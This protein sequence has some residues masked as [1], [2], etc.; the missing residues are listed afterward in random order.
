MKK[1]FF[2]FVGLIIL[3]GAGCNKQDYQIPQTISSTST[4][5]YSD[6]YN[7]L[8]VDVNGDGK[9][10]LITLTVKRFEGYVTTTLYVNDLSVIVPGYDPAGYFGMVDIDS[11]DNIR[12][13]AV[14]DVGPSD[15]YTTNFYYF[16]G[17]NLLFMGTIPWVYK[18]MTFDGFGKIITK[19]RGKIL[20]TWFYDDDFVIS[21]NHELVHVPKNL[22]VRDTTVTLLT[23][24]PLQ[25]SPLNSKI[26][27]NL[28]KGEIA[29]II[30]CD[31]IAW[32]V[33]EKSDGVHGWFAV[34]NFDIVKGVGLHAGDVFLGLSNAD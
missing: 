1:L 27:T 15:D 12:E 23:A 18:D 7:S 16:N 17:T 24:L 31:D 10:E 6:D 2:A 26:I 14:I 25:I 19:T 3:T 4:Y 8:Q 29:K 9:E 13:I 11:Q 33:I 5:L 21:K 20:D 28:N 32:C 34:E 30:G 22:Y